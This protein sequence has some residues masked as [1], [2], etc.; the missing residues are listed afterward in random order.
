MRWTV[1]PVLV[2]L[3]IIPGAAREKAGFADRPVRIVATMF[4]LAEFARAVSGEQGVVHT[5]IPP[6]AEVHSWRPRP[7]DIVRV[8]KADLFIYVGGGMEPWVD[9]LLESARRPERVVLEASRG[10]DLMI[11]DEE[12]RGEGGHA[13]KGGHVVDPHIWLDFGFDQNI[14]GRISRHLCGISPG[15][16]EIFQTNAEAYRKRLEELDRIYAEKLADHAGEIFVLGGHAAFGYLARRYGLRQEALYGLSPNAKPTPRQMIRIIETARQHEIRV[17][18]FEV[19]VS[20]E[21]AGIIAREA[22]AETA[23]LNPGANLT[24]R[25][26]EG[27]VTFIDIM[28]DNLRA[29]ENGFRKR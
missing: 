29:L 27:G 24:R 25:Q 1:V 21:L 2:T 12:P 26:R 9:D 7:S 4:P 17:I 8:S 23:V 5:L 14:V 28:L 15:H 11:R 10:L 16:S 19:Q 13:H 6:G 18:Y 22:G 20:D 3:L